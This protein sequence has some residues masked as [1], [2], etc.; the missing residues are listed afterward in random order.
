[1]TEETPVI[2]T[3]NTTRVVWNR[4]FSITLLMNSEW[5]IENG[6]GVNEIL[7][8]AENIRVLV[9]DSPTSEC[10]AA[11][12]R[13]SA[14]APIIILGGFTT[15]TDRKWDAFMW[16]TCRA[17]CTSSRLHFRSP[18]AL[19]FQLPVVGVV[20]SSPFDIISKSPR[21]SK[22]KKSLQ[23]QSTSFSSSSDALHSNDVS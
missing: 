22:S 16:T 18:L 3:M 6:V 9:V 7:K 15:T 12:S 17:Q 11:C 1:M 23:Q 20:F 13:C 5:G 10:V 2:L 14:E 8:T 4:P 21:A 19:A